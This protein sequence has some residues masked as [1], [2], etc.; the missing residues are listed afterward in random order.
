MNLIATVI[1]LGWMLHSGMK[2]QAIHR[3]GYSPIWVGWQ[4]LATVALIVPM[5]AVWL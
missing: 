4:W 1:L 5:I 2:A 3:E